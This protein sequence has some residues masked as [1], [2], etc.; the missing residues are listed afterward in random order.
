MSS[1]DGT[2]LPVRPLS[3]DDLDEILDLDAAA[4]G[5]DPPRDF[6]DEVFVPILEL[7]RIVG[8]RD[9][10]AENELVAAA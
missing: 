8:A 2:A 9:P 5:A 4:F 3:A 7:D 6:V 10:A 1:G